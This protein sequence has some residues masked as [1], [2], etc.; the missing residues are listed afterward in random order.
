MRVEHGIRSSNWNDIREQAAWA[1]SRNYDGVV[2]FEL[3]N[4]PFMSLA[5]A[6]AATQHVRLGLS[7]IHI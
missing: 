1:E 2:T 7:L 3:N 4:D 5:I 6:T